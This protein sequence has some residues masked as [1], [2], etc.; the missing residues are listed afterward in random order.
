MRINS[1]SLHS[2]LI[3]NHFLDDVEIN[4]L[5]SLSPLYSRNMIS[6]PLQ[7]L[8]EKALNLI[9]EGNILG[10]SLS[11]ANPVFILSEAYLLV[12]WFL[13]FFHYF[14]GLFF[15]IFFHFILL[16]FLNI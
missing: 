8:L 9:Y 2:L 6:C 14:P 7:S 3:S 13:F 4:D 1:L 12:S 11:S 15:F 10:G 5:V 16:L